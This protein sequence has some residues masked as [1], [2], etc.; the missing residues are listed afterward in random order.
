MKSKVKKKA[1]IQKIEC[2]ECSTR[3]VLE[4]F[5]L[6]NGFCEDCFVKNFPSKETYQGYKVYL[7][8]NSKK[9]KKKDKKV[10]LRDTLGIPKELWLPDEGIY[11][12]RFH[13]KSDSSNNLYIVSTNSRNNN[14]WGCA[15]PGWKRHRK[16][17]HLKK[18]GLCEAGK[19]NTF[20]SG[21]TQN[22]S[23]PTA[24]EIRAGAG[25]SSYN[26]TK[27]SEISSKVDNKKRKITLDE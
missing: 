20:A 24:G 10:E 22:P 1:K 26:P 4:E 9:G 6:L 8:S 15:C 13:V 27:A 14:S 21:Y 5:L 12:N 25:Y 3:I 23:I 18:L 2:S 7:K 19:V 17:R 11:Q 16:C